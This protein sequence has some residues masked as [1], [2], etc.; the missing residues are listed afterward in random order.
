MLL[1]SEGVVPDNDLVHLFV[2][3]NS[4]Q[5]ISLSLTNIEIIVFQ[6]E[7]T[8]VAARHSGLDIGIL[9]YQGITRPNILF[10]IR[11]VV[12]YFRIQRL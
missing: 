12:E 9:V 6:S 1:L 2:R 10:E 4:H 7:R 11:V 5:A 3:Q 8:A